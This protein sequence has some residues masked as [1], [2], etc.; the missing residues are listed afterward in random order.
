[1]LLDYHTSVVTLQRK[2]TRPA[3]GIVA[4]FINTTTTISNF[5]TAGLLV[6]FKC[7]SSTLPHTHKTQEEFSKNAF[8]ACV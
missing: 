8:E 1:M 5:K 2:K 3:A 4:V 7:G 6:L